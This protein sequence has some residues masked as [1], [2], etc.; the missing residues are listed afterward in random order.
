[1]Q[2]NDRRGLRSNAKYGERRAW[3]ARR[4]YDM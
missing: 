1:M 3:I 2:D 4:C